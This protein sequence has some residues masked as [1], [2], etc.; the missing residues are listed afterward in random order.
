[1]KPQTLNFEHQFEYSSDERGDTF[2]KLV[3]RLINPADPTCAI[4]FDGHLDS[5]AGRSLLNGQLAA[6]IGLDLLAGPEIHYQTAMGAG[7]AA[8]EHHVEL[9]HEMLGRF[10]L[11]LGFSTGNIRRNLLGRDFFARIQVA[12]REQH[13]TFFVTARP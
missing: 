12:F 4:D 7:I 6:A 9:E 13:H 3:L 11:P 8:R 10:N 1:M 2:P 5:G